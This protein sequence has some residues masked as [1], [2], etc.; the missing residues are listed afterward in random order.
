MISYTCNYKG[1]QRWQTA[2]KEMVDCES[3][4]LAR[5]KVIQNILGSEGSESGI[6]SDCDTESVEEDEDHSR[7]LEDVMRY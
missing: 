7:T 5:S 6:M 3:L 2:C 1:N 4:I